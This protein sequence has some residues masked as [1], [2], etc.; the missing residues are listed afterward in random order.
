M[1]ANCGAKGKDR[2]S[3]FQE[4]EEQTQGEKRDVFRPGIEIRRTHN[5]VRSWS[6]QNGW[7]PPP[8]EDG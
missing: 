4:E 8:A 6:S 7:P 5:H 1:E 3:R 2:T